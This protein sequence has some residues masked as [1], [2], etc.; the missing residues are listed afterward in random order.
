[1]NINRGE[2]HSKTLSTGLQ[3]HLIRHPG[4]DKWQINSLDTSWGSVATGML[5]TKTWFAERLGWAKYKFDST[6]A[7]Y[8]FLEKH[9]RLSP[10][11]PAT[12]C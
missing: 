7:A 3:A 6:D 4:S 5:T 11:V 1:M 12:Q 10:Q 9:A 8:G 2:H